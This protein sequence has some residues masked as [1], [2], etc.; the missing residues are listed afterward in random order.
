[1]KTA[2][3]LTI[4]FGLSITAFAQHEQHMPQ[5]PANAAKEGSVIKKDSSEMKQDSMQMMTHSYS[6][7]LP[8][9]RNSSGTAWQP[10]ATPIYGYMKM[11]K[12]WNLMFHGSV[13][14][15]Y[16]HQ[17][18]N[19]EGTRADSLT[20]RVDAPNWVMIMADRKI[21]K[22]GLLALSLMLSADEWVMNGDGYP[23]LFQSGETDDGK[24]LVDRQHP[25]DLIS[26][27]S[28]GYTH[29]LSQHSD[30]TFYNGYPGEPALGPPAFM[31]RI[32]TF[33]NPSAPLAHHWQDATHIT[34]GVATIGY[35]YKIVKFE[36]SSFT[37]REPD[38]NRYDFD[39]LRFDSYSYRITTNPNENFSIQ[40]SQGFLKSPES[41]EP[42]KNIVRSTASVMHAIILGEKKHLTSSLVWGMNKDTKGKSENSALIE[43]NLQINKFAFYGKGELLQ[44]NAHE[45]QLTAFE[46]D[47]NFLIG[48]LTLGSNFN[49]MSDINTNL[50]VGLQGSI[51][52][53]D[54]DLEAYYGKTPL[55]LE[56]YLR[57][58]PFNTNAL[59][60]H[61]QK[62]EH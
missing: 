7:S 2:I 26:G 40:F 39:K 41:L 23:L 24:P 49:L 58:S 27:L 29:M 55:S 61:H 50:K 48:L 62:K 59:A 46:D 54:Q 10:D 35:R 32:S 3:L 19:S 53:P 5:Q 31:H 20:D 11:T 57:F 56:L 9:N 33:N 60:M 13:F 4:Q 16:N 21:K 42:E 51:Y 14:L 15:R 47:R 12:R 38:E 22:R 6:L 25:H 52:F 18:I 36:A 8:M 28:A 17:G 45:L 1:M 43:S 30:I 34:F 44:K 37:G